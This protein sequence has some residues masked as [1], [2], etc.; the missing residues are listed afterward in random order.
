MNATALSVPAGAL[1]W[2]QE[3]FRARQIPHD[4]PWRRFDEEVLPFRDPDGLPLELVA[5]PA[6]D[7]RPEWKG[8]GVPAEYAIRGVYGVTAHEE[9]C[10][11]ERTWRGPCFVRPDGEGR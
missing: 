5:R 9:G 11:Q 3:R 2:W 10:K 8:G 7:P 4:L 6:V 1:P